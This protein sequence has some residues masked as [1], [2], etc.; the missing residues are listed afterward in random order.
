VPTRRGQRPGDRRPL[1]WNNFGGAGRTCWN[2]AVSMNL[3]AYDQP[4]TVNFSTA[5]VIASLTGPDA[6][7]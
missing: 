6:G 4:T 3:N 5:G 7:G 1:D 2:N